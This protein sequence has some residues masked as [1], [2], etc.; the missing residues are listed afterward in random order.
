MYYF[1][2]LF[3]QKKA[4]ERDLYEKKGKKRKK[5]KEKIPNISQTVVVIKMTSIL[6]AFISVFIE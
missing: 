3:M 2:L 5:E 1:L 4:R 6:F